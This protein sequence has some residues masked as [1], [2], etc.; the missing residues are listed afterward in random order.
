VT[1]PN[2]SVDGRSED[3]DAAHT[4]DFEETDF[5]LARA[6]LEEPPA[7]VRIPTAPPTDWGKLRRERA[8][9]ED[10]QLTQQAQQWLARLPAEIQPNELCTRYPRLANQLAEVWGNGALCL[11]RIDGLLVDSRGARRGFPSRI[12]LELV[13]LRDLRV[14]IERRARA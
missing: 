9:W 6:A 3:T 8:A 10:T 4:L 7:G 12:A 11:E 14:A 2:N 1:T 13:K 5:A